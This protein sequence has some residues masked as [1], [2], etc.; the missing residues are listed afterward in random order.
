MKLLWQLAK[1]TKNN[2]LNCA[3][4]LN[5]HPDPGITR[6]CCIYD[7]AY[8]G[9]RCLGRGLRCLSAFLVHISVLSFETLQYKVQD[10]DRQQTRWMTEHTD[11]LLVWQCL[12]ILSCLLL[13]A[14]WYDALPDAYVP[15]FK[16]KGVSINDINVILFTYRPHQRL[17]MDHINFYF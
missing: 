5:H 17:L 1:D 7:S 16:H 8:Y 6:R 11:K 13:C 9:M 12:V 14:S 15:V 10:N 2:W 3:G 4:D